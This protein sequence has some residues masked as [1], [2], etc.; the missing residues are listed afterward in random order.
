MGTR[1]GLRRVTEH[2]LSGVTAR[3]PNRGGRFQL[4]LGIGRHYVARAVG[5]WFGLSHP[6]RYTFALVGGPLPSSHSARSFPCYRLPLPPS[7][8]IPMMTS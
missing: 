4:V 8:S 3:K 7:G 1:V 6:I 5:R 2:I